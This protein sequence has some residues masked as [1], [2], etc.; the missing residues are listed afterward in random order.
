MHFSLVNSVAW[1]NIFIP[2]RPVVHNSHP[3]CVQRI[4]HETTRHEG[5]RKRGRA[6]C[7]KEGA[8]GEGPGDAG[9]SGEENVERKSNERERKQILAQRIDQGVLKESSLE[10]NS[11]VALIKHP[12]FV[13]V[14]HYMLKS[15]AV[16]GSVMQ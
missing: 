16:K 6:Q 3:Q 12:R 2:L 11:P 1:E 13:L 15:W 8:P 9:H 5:R 7:R 10:S 4:A 14:Y